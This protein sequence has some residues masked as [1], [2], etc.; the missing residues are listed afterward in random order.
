M[1]TKPMRIRVLPIATISLLLANTTQAQVYPRE[2]TLFTPA[3]AGPVITGLSASGGQSQDQLYIMGSGFGVPNVYQ[4]TVREVHFA[5]NGQDLVA[6]VN[7]Y[8]TDTEIHVRVPTFQYVLPGQSAAI[9]VVKKLWDKPVATSASRTFS[10]TPIYGTRV[11]CLEAWPPGTTIIKPGSME[12]ASQWPSSVA[13]PGCVPKGAVLH[14]NIDLFTGHS[15]NDWFFMGIKLTNSWVVENV[16][17]GVYN[18]QQAGAVIASFN[19]GSNDVVTN[20][21]WWADVGA[22]VGVTYTIAV[23]I[24][25]PADVPDG[26]LVR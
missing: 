10:Y 24:R 2:K 18:A 20:I 15:G 1:R 25:G 4:D 9:Y 22:L 17:L 26:W 23:V 21:R 3:P 6:P 13:N 19:K 12:V 14:R 8:W 5:M 7:G 11:Y 16:I